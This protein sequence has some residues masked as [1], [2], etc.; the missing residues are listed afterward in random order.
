MDEQ[1][2]LT[3][4][5]IFSASLKVSKSRSL[6]KRRMQSL[7]LKFT[8]SQDVRNRLAGI[9]KG[10]LKC[11][12]QFCHD[13]DAESLSA[14]AIILSELFLLQGE[15]STSNE[16]G[17]HET[18]YWTVAQGPCDEWV[19][20]LLASEN[21]RRTFNSFRITFD[22]SEERRSLV[23]KNAKMLGSYLLP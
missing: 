1:I 4:N 19:Q 8:E 6:V 21:G 2:T 7:G 22:N 11:V 3:Q 23:E 14:M 10:A 5:Q 16:Y 15:L 13:N 12:G 17:D 20:S 9:E 18:S